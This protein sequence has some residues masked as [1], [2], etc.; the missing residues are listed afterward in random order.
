MANEQHNV[1]VGEEDNHGMP[2][3]TIG[4]FITC[5]VSH[6]FASCFVD[7]V[8]DGQSDFRGS[9]PRLGVWLTLST[10]TRPLHFSH[11]LLLQTTYICRFLAI[12]LITLLLL[13]SCP[14]DNTLRRAQESQNRSV[15]ACFFCLPPLPLPAFHII[16]F[17]AW[18][19]LL[20]S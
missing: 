17:L 6:K 7:S 9:M 14:L 8:R 1:H 11:A 18:P 10:K 3:L 16:C 5:P 12:R 19:I 15:D 2:Q 20:L 13:Q 4:P